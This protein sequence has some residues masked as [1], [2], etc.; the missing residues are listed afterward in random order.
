M[1]V[2]AFIAGD[3]LALASGS[4]WVVHVITAPLTVATMVDTDLI[5]M[6]MSFQVMATD[7]QRRLMVTGIAIPPTATGDTDIRGSD[8]VPAA[9]IARELVAS[10]SERLAVT[11][12]EA[13]RGDSSLRGVFLVNARLSTLQRFA[14]S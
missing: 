9:A 7:T 3:G 8:E 1:V 13:P 12:Y 14:A 10:H 6:G 2:S 11:G 5:D 4:M